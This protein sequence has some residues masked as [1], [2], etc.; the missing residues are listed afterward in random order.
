MEEYY[1]QGV[2]DNDDIDKPSTSGTG[3]DKGK[4]AATK[5]AGLEP[6]RRKTNTE[7]VGVLH[8]M[9]GE[10]RAKENEVSKKV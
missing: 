1:E 9:L 2:D 6:K 5:L 3:I 10:S 8:Q 4:T 7:V